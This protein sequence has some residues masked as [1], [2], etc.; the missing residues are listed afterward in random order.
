[1]VLYIPQKKE[2]EMG[3][4]E[5]IEANKELTAFVVKANPGR[6]RIIAAVDEKGLT[7]SLWIYES[8][9]KGEI[10]YI[11]P[12]TD[13]EID[14]WD[15]AKYNQD[16]ARATKILTPEGMMEVIAKA[17]KEARVELRE[18]VD[19]LIAQAVD[20]KE[21]QIKRLEAELAEAK[22]ARDTHYTQTLELTAE[23]NRQR[24]RAEAR[25]KESCELE[26][27]IEDYKKQVSVLNVERNQEQHTAEKLRQGLRAQEE[28]MQNL[29]FERDN[30]RDIATSR[31]LKIERLNRDIAALNAR[32]ANTFSA[33]L[34]ETD[35]SEQ[36]QRIEELEKETGR[37]ELALE[38]ALNDLANKKS[39]AVAGHRLGQK[40]LSIFGY[41]A[42][43]SSP[44]WEIR[45]A[46]AIADRAKLSPKDTLEQIRN[47]ANE[48]MRFDFEAGTWIFE[49]IDS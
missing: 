9:S 43:D 46:E 34:S 41:I 24:N 15:I 49:R 26:A 3:I 31:K 25:E 33:T 40:V 27:E 14:L 11:R 36:V 18:D 30:N 28:S 12:A 10:E 13:A 23:V 6:Y 8:I 39:M 21:E 37:L 16:E 38:A 5:E 47:R 19:R 48:S 35:D 42:T 7:E 1:M 29:Q 17:A 4:K 32:L 45:A 2:T 44:Y 22:G 20:E